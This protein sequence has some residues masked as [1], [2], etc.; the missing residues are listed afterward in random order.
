MFQEVMLPLIEMKNYT[1][2]VVEYLVNIIKQNS[3]SSITKDQYL[4]LLNV[5][6]SSKK[7]LPSDLNNQ[8]NETASKLNV[9]L[10]EQNGDKKYH[11]FIEP[12]VKRL[13]DNN[14]AHYQ[15]NVCYVIVTCLMR[16][17]VS[18]ETWDKIYTKHLPQSALILKY[19]GECGRN[20]VFFRV[21]IL[22]FA[23]VNWNSLAGKINAKKFSNLLDKFSTNNCE[24]MLK[25]PK[26]AGLADS[27]TLIKVR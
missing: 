23:D 9:L 26:E 7:N 11:N 5:I 12:F 1:R 15:N 8:L 18:F 24:L 25:K 20:I 16:D 19:I 4:L 14:N 2:Y 10:L 17:P 3:K 13:S 22:L 27:V 6:F 21:Y